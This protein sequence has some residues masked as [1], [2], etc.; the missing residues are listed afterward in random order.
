MQD[1]HYITKK[2]Y[3]QFLDENQQP[4]SDQL[5]ITNYINVST[6]CSYKQQEE[7]TKKLVEFIIQYVQPLY[8]LQVDAFQNLLLTCEPGYRI[9][10]DKTVKGILYSAYEWSKEQLHSL[11]SNN[12]IAVHLTTDLWTAKTCHG[13]LGITATWLIEEFEFQ[14][15]LLICNHFLILILVR[16]LVMNYQK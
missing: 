5:Q 6:L 12:I 7:I 8:I 14:E 4:R 15:A 11:L 2:N 3:L 1:R 13:Y 10:C 16:L 9:P